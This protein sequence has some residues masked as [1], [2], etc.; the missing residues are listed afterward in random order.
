MRL[1]AFTIY[2][3][4]LLYLVDAVHTIR[5]DIKFLLFQQKSA[6]NTAMATTSE[7]GTRRDAAGS[8]RNAAACK[9][10]Y[11]PLPKKNKK[12]TAAWRDHAN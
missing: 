8:P 7:V 3:F 11:C 6:Q 9:L 12:L 4:L 10:D 5:N 1:Y 2:L